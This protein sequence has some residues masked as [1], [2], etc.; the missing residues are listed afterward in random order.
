LHLL[1]L[2]RA[3]IA[4]APARSNWKFAF[5]KTVGQTLARRLRL[6]SEPVCALVA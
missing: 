4:K 5:G 3:M 1:N 2:R 6:G